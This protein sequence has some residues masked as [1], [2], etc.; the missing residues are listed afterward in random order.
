MGAEETQE[1]ISRI[2]GQLSNL[3]CALSRITGVLQS[4]GIPVP[5]HKPVLLEEWEPDPYGNL[6]NLLQCVER[7]ASYLAVW[8]IAIQDRVAGELRN[9]VRIPSNA[10]DRKTAN[11]RPAG[12]EWRYMEERSGNDRG[13]WY[14]RKDDA[15]ILR[16]VRSGDVTY[17]R[18]GLREITQ[19]EAERKSISSEA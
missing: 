16:V 3:Q 4:F 9:T 10:S 8:A 6:Q 12:I 13:H 1:K 2:L 15:T 7:R 18:E 17:F 19:E 5:D 14:V 11:S